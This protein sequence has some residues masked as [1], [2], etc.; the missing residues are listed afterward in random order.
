MVKKTLLQSKKER[1]KEQEREKEMEV[2]RQQDL[3]RLEAL[4]PI[5]EKKEDQVTK[6]EP[7]SEVSLARKKNLNLRSLEV[8]KEELD[9]QKL[10]LFTLLQDQRKLRMFNT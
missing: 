7:L 6:M 10:F 8:L 4:Q 1:R 3:I 5:E 9:K 2:Q